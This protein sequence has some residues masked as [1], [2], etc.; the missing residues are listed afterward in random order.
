M[1][2]LLA[3]EY[4]K[5]TNKITTAR[6]ARQKGRGQQAAIT[7]RVR[8]GMPKNLSCDWW[9]WFMKVSLL[10]LYLV[11]ASLQYMCTETGLQYKG[12]AVHLIQA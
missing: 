8:I 3:M 7:I 10:G 12:T 9:T 2:F 6:S 5:Q 11:R 4:S 1:M